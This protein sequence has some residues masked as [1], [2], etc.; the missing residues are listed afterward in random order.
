MRLLWAAPFLYGRGKRG[1]A[2]AAPIGLLEIP[3]PEGDELGERAAEN[4][5]L[6]V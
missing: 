4:L 5:R 3:S 2:D 6:A 1:G